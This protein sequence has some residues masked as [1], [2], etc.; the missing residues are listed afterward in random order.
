LRPLR[1]PVARPE[2][3]KRGLAK[4]PAQERQDKREFGEDRLPIL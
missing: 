2:A 1:E 3:G 4:C